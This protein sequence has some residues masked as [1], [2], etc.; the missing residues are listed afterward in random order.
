V[1]DCDGVL[2]DS[3]RVKSQAYRTALAGEPP[4]RIDA[5]YDWFHA[6]PGHTR[7][8]LFEHF[9]AVIAGVPDWRERV[10]AACA[11][12]AGELERALHACPVVPGADGFL[13][14]L[15]ERSASSAIVSAALRSDLDA[16][17]ARRGWDGRFRAVCGGEKTKVAHIRDLRA[18][19]VLSAGGLYFGDSS[20]DMESAEATGCHF[21]Y[22]SGCSEWRDGP[23]ICRVRGHREIVD[24]TDPALGR[25]LDAL[26]CTLA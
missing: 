26:G 6:H 12:F 7:F 15:S 23:A 8:A 25:H 22:V 14:R 20:I 19:G 21:I 17:V 11:V 16:V 10:T 2:I 5:F 1:F 9:Y 24:F 13:A 4:G 3:N 18:A